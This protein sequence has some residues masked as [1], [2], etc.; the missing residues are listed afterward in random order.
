MNRTKVIVGCSLVVLAAACIGQ[1]MLDTPS[2]KETQK[3]NPAPTVV[4]AE[5]TPVSADEVVGTFLPS[6]KDGEEQSR[7]VALSGL[8]DVLEGPEYAKSSIGKENGDALAEA[9]APLVHTS[10]E[11]AKESWALKIR[12]A[13]LIVARTTAPA[14]RELVLKTLESGPADLRDAVVGELGRPDG[15]GGKKVFQKLQETAATIPAGIY[16]PALRRVGGK[17]A[18]EPI[19]A[20]MKGSADPAVVTACA[21]ALEDYQD[22][23]LMGSILE[24]LEQTGMID[25]GVKMPWISWTL[26]NK[27]LE[28]SEGSTL[29]RGVK[30][31]RSRPTL[32]R[33]GAAIFERAF[34]KGDEETRRIASEAVKKAVM[35][36]S[37]DG[38]AAE[39]LLAAHPAQEPAPVLKAALPAAPEQP[40]AQ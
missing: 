29:A 2:Q 30:V 39:K 32:A 38:E 6:V 7:L 27:H 18:V 17:K 40:K 4:Q 11:E 19:T 1:L 35:I 36:K 31:L 26:L 10:S 15:I 23:A 22:P 21:I 14:A 20:M 34:E 24:R 9:I 37:F 5:T 16:A 25:D 3:P 33:H 8:V 13:K 28:T 12:G